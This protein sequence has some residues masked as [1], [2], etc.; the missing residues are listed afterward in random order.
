M[1]KGLAEV[2]TDLKVLN[3]RSM[4]WSQFLSIG[5]LMTKNGTTLWNIL[6]Q[7]TVVWWKYLHNKNIV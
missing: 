7:I 6:G 2:V 4:L 5:P 1:G 3:L